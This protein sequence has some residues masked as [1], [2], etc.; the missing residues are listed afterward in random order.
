MMMMMIRMMMMTMMMMMM[1]LMLMM[2]LTV[3][4]CGPCQEYGGEL[5]VARSTNSFGSDHVSFQRAGIP[6]ILFI[7]QDDTNYD[8]YHRDCDSVDRVNPGQSA[9]IV[10][11]CAGSLVDLASGQAPYGTNQTVVV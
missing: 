3:C 1:M 7:E 10:R 2:M 8:C 4:G 5:T 11:G 6:A 9:D